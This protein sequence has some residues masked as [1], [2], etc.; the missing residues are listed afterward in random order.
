MEGHHREQEGM[1]EPLQ[2][3][4]DKGGASWERDWCK[5]EV[6]LK[7]LRNQAEAKRQNRLRWRRT[8]GRLKRWGALSHQGVRAHLRHPQ[9]GGAQ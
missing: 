9:R 1:R 5:E 4:K 7:H 6:Q 2:K 3:P 8:A